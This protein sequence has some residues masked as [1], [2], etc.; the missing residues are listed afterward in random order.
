M[1]TL[2]SI[3]LGL[4]LLVAGIAT[5]AEKQTIS[6]LSKNEVLNIYVNAVIH[7]KIEGVENILSA[8]VKQ[9]IFRGEKEFK[10]DKK[11]IIESFKATEN[12]EQGCTYTTT[13]VDETDKGMVVKLVMKYEGYTRTNLVTI[14]TN[15]AE[16]KVTK[17]ETLA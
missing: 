4:A 10:L 16:F 1:K 3:M 8:D 15:K 13:I 17:I 11:Q 14:S 2:K 7:G 12:V 5:A 6:T 9:S